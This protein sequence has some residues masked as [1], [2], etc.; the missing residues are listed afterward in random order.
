M[1]N[2]ACVKKVSDSTKLRAP[3]FAHKYVLVPTIIHTISF[4]PHLGKKTL[5]SLH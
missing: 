3:C 1:V 4:A 5:T 2:Y